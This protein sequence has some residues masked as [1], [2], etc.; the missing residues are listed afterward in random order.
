MTMEKTK[1]NRNNK[2]KITQ[3]SYDKIKAKILENL[4]EK[5][6]E[7]DEWLIDSAARSQIMILKIFNELVHADLLV[8]T[9]YRRPEI[10]NQNPLFTMLLA[11]E[12][13]NLKTLDALGLTRKS[14]KDTAISKDTKDPLLSYRNMNGSQMENAQ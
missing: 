12:A 6:L 11:A 2:L 9:D 8:I 7:A 4:G 10:L 5:K 13:Q 1:S 3:G 14:R